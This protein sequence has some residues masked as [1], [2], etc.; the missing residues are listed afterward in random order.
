VVEILGLG[1]P[2]HSASNNKR[3]KSKAKCQP[4]AG[5]SS[6]GSYL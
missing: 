3:I 2:S 5:S 6:A 4:A 1:L